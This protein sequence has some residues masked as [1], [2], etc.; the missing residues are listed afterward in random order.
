[1]NLYEQSGPDTFEKA[2]KIQMEPLEFQPPLSHRQ[3]PVAAVNP[4]MRVPQNSQNMSSYNFQNTSSSGSQNISST[5]YVA[6]KAT[7]SGSSPEPRPSGMEVS[8]LKMLIDSWIF[9]ASC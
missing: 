8:H 5:D 9:M 2:S 6:N 3:N 7:M 1:M 4:S